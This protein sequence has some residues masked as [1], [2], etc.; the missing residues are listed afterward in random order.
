MGRTITTIH[1][2]TFLINEKG[3]I[4]KIIHKVWAGKASSQ[5]LET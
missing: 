5:I 1:R 4:E 3:V 2:I